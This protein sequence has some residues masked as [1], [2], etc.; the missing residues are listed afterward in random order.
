[1]SIACRRSSHQKQKHT[2]KKEGKSFEGT[3]IIRRQ[4][5]KE[6]NVGGGCTCMH[7]LC[8]DPDHLKQDHTQSQSAMLSKKQVIR[9]STHLPRPTKRLLRLRHHPLL[10][11]QLRHNP[12]LQQVLL[13][14]PTRVAV[15]KVTKQPIRQPQQRIQPLLF[16][17]TPLHQVEDRCDVRDQ[18]MH[19]KYNPDDE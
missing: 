15:R 10:S 4:E 14:L 7:L 5:L 2:G 17:Q 1:V 3:T 18:Q 12:L 19:C 9:R 13:D 8:C 16:A 11:P 6:K